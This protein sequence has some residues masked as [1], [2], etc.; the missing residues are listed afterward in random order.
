VI[1]AYS[2]ATEFRF[3]NP[4]QYSAEYMQCLCF[5][6]ISTAVEAPT[7]ENKKQVAENEKA[8]S[9]FFKNRLSLVLFPSPLFSTDNG[10]RLIW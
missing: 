2:I 7:Y 6:L 3:H 1:E 4:L 8:S 10:D 5:H 9:A